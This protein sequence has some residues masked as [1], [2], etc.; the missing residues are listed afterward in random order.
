[1]IVAIESASTDLSVA[2]AADDGALLATAGWRS[3][4]RGGHDLLPRLLDLLA[5]EGHRLDEAGA[6]AVGIGPGSFTGLRVGMSVA[7]GLA[8]GLRRPIVGVP[9]L[10]AW[11]AA[12][13]EATAALARAG[14]REAY[15][16]LR[17]ESTPLIVD[18][19]ELPARAGSA[20]LVAPGELAE[21][22][23][24]TGAISPS[25]GAAA[26][27]AIAAARLTA[28]ATGDDLTRLEP[29]YLRPPRGLGRVV[30]A[31]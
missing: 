21:A 17:G 11:L 10:D 30:R 13:P 19:D 27:A 7:K 28:Q 2:L 29:A 20:T 25:G 12:V 8:L 15:L 5:R 31:E 16:L 24:L 26:V 23:A 4:S 6:F 1:M 3:E 14:A 9:S 22:F 18:R